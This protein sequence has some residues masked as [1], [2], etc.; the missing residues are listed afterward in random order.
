M[1][2]TLLLLGL[3]GAMAAGL[4]TLQADEASALVWKDCQRI[5]LCEGCRPVYK[6]RVGALRARAAAR[7]PHHPSALAFPL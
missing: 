7:R 3:A 1:R 6:C 4:V 2:K 5:A